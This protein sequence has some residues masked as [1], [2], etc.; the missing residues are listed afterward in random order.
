MQTNIGIQKMVLS[1]FLKEAKAAPVQVCS[2]R[3]VEAKP[4]ILKQ[5]NEYS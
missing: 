4:T 1:I 5:W 2:L 3:A